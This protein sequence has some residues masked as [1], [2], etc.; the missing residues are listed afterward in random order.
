MDVTVSSKTL[1]QRTGVMM[2]EGI[3][4]LDVAEALYSVDAEALEQNAELPD[5][6]VIGVRHKGRVTGYLALPL[7]AEAGVIPVSPEQI[8]PETAGISDVIR[9]LDGFPCCFVEV[10]GEIAGLVTR[11][12]MEKPPVRMW[13]FGIFTIIE[14][15][16]SRKLEALF[17]DHAWTR[18]VTS[19]R[20]E[21][22]E[23][24]QAERERRGIRTPLVDC[25]QLSDKMQILLH[26]PEMREDFG[27]SSRREGKRMAKALESL[28][29][30]L[31]HNQPIAAL[32]WEA[33]VMAA[34][35]LERILSRL[36]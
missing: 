18:H 8:V 20:L 36:G 25:L 12:D 26:A 4:A 29:N 23:A 35:R 14:P 6:E 19:A 16:C 28:R 22:T 24:L 15:Y 33:M 11:E 10:F 27:M 9:I 34:K 13:L 17:P 31:A 32:N 2:T 30:D 3:C 1:R 5:A 21:K 7:E